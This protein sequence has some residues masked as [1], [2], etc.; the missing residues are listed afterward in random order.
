MCLRNLAKQNNSREPYYSLCQ[1][2]ASYAPI[3]ATM[4][5]R[6]ETKG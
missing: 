2:E 6:R 1:Q 5:P 4:S 3:T